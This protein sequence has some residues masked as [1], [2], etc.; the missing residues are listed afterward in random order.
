MIKRYEIDGGWEGYREREYDNGDWVKFDDCEK[1]LAIAEAAVKYV[2]LSEKRTAALK[3]G[4]S[5]QEDVAMCD[6]ITQAL[7]ELIAVVEGEEP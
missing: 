5:F 7:D 1:P 6:E 4:M 3:S 2:R